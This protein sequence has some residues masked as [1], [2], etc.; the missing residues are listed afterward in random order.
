MGEK[1]FLCWRHGI[2]EGESCIE[3]D[4][5]VL[6]DNGIRAE[7]FEEAAKIARGERSGPS[8]VDPDYSMDE[9]ANNRS[10]DIA[11]LLEA[12]AKELRDG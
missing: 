4:G 2:Y 8:G 1:R 9:N 7:V 12:K 6:R 5:E 10:D 3:C 11:D